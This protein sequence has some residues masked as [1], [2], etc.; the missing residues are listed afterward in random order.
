MCEAELIDCFAHAIEE[1]NLFECSSSHLFLPE[2]PLPS[3]LSIEWNSLRLG[4]IVTK[5]LPGSGRYQGGR[6]GGLV[7]VG[8]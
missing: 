3:V 1:S 2:S 7:V 8:W 5:T 6:G 4:G